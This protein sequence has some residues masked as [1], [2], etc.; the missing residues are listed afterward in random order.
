MERK[1]SISSGDSCAAGDG[2][3]RFM[4]V[5]CSILP[6]CGAAQPVVDGL[7]EPVIRHRHHRDRA[8]TSC[9]EGAKIA[10]KIGGGFS[11]IAALGQVH[12]GGCMGS[13]HPVGAKSKQYL[14]GLQ[15]VR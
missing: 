14:A 3:T 11:E 6:N 12:R 13:R 8:R 7:A 5:S 10:E 9:I 2:W 4:P 1:R 15:P